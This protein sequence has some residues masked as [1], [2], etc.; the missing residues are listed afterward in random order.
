MLKVPQKPP[1]DS[2]CGTQVIMVAMV[3]EDHTCLLAFGQDADPGLYHNEEASLE[4]EINKYTK[5]RIPT[6]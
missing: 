6:T 3:T 2:I 4:E 5:Y 1:V